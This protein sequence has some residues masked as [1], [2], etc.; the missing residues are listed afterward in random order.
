MHTSPIQWYA[1]VVPRVHAADFEGITIREATV[2]L[3]RNIPFI[4]D[5]NF[6]VRDLLVGWSPTRFGGPGSMA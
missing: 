3:P 4:G 5:V 6:G 1:L 2:Y